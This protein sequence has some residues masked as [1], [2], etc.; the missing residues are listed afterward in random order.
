MKFNVT[1]S[2]QNFSKKPS[3]KEF[4]TVQYV[5]K[6]L[7]LDDIIASIKHGNVLSAN[8]TTD[9]NSIITQ[10]HRRNDNIIGT[11]FV[12]FDLD[13]DVESN[14]AGL[15]KNIE[16]KPT[17]AYTTYSH[18]LVGKGNRYR[19]LYFFDKEILNIDIYR[20][21]YDIIKSKNN[22]SINDG[23]GRNIS[24]AV[25][26]SHTECE[27]INTNIVYSI[28]QF[29]LDNK[30]T[31]NGHSNSI[32]KEEK[33]NIKIECPIQDKEYI[34][35]FNNM[36]YIAL[37]EKYNDKYC[38][39][40]HTPLEPVDADT[41]YII[42][43]PNYIEIIRYW[44]YNINYDEHGE[45]RGKSSRARKI[46]D[47]E[48]R[49]KKLYINGILRRL[50]MDN[51]TFEHLL[52][53]LVNE[54]YYF[55]DNSNDYI[56]KKQL[57]EIAQSSYNA[58]LE[59]YKA[60]NKRMEKRKYIVNDEYCIKYGLTRCQV[61]NLSRKYITYSKIGDL[62]DASLTDKANLEVFKECGL[63]ISAKT[64]QRFRKEMG[65]IKYKKGNGHSNFIKK[66]EESNIE[67]ER[68]IQNLDK[69]YY[70]Y[71]SEIILSEMDN[72][73][74]E[75]FYDISDKNDIKAMA[76]TFIRRAKR[77]NPNYNNDELIEIFK[78]H[79]Q[80]AS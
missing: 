69:A 36:S 58:N 77:I 50:M 19:L 4:M 15:I 31:R 10:L 55:I 29:Q 11:S 23:C 38:F 30:G 17:I 21:I 79:F 54:L 74:N 53:C 47:G 46:K 61:R 5:R 76:Q 62:F 33:S 14:L 1:V 70:D 68:P 71:Q 78:N 45:E 72:D 73:I 56:S 2:L 18:G 32:K 80:L 3:K 57:V 48:G 20:G 24:Q 27:L 26:G 37:I 13:D 75:G 51:L 52:H 67:L 12:M 34:A 43:P 64:L 66:E 60:I 22:M 8:Y 28:E 35:D 6:S 65:I 44:I 39:F 7:S 40:Q 16:I 41:P 49:K 9:Y 42:L 59:D 63:E 25:L